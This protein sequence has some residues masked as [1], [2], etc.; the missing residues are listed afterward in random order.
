[1]AAAY[2]VENA[3]MAWLK[4]EWDANAV[5]VA[6]SDADALKLVL[7]PLDRSNARG[8]TGPAVQNAEPTPDTHGEAWARITVRQDTSHQKSI[9]PKG[10]RRFRQT[11]SIYVQVFASVLDGGAGHK[12]SSD[13][14]NMVKNVYQGQSEG[15]VTCRDV[16]VRAMGRD[17]PWYAHLVTVFFEWD[18]IN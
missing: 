7:E 9:N 12:V 3:V 15:D 16:Q 1:M 2:D 4:T 14:A 18:E 17:G 13:L 11:G 8:G 10:S 6:G 5:A